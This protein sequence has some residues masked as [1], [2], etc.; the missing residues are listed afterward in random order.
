MDWN[1]ECNIETKILDKPNAQNIDLKI[2]Y[3]D[4]YLAVINKP[5]NMV[6]HPTETQNENTLVKCNYV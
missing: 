4:E 5:Y 6:A 3:E 2:E 1:F